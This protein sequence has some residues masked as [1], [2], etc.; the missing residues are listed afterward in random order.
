MQVVAVVPNMALQHHEF[1]LQLRDAERLLLFL[2]AGMAE[3]EMQSASLKKAKLACR[4]LELEARESTKRAAQTEAKR[5]AACHEAAMAKLVT[6]GAVNTRAQIESELIWVQRALALPEE[7]RQRA[8]S[9]HGAA[10]EALAAAGEACT[11]AEEENGRLADKKLA[12]VLELGSVNDEFSTFWEKVAVDRE[13][14]EA[15]F[16][17]NDDTLFN[18]GYGCCAFTHNICGSKPHIPDGISDPSIPFT[19]EFFSNPRCPISV[20]STAPALD[21]IVGGEDEHSRSSPTAVGEEVVLSIDPPAM[22]DGGVEDIASNYWLLLLS[23]C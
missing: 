2:Q 12:L 15:E 18:Y 13:T 3:R 10:R 14:M 19:S 20:S 17:F 5:D 22:S 1:E 16:D 23:F 8:E 9:E 6:K 21:T 11:K 4:R 7:A